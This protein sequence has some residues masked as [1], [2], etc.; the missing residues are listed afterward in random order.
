VTSPRPQASYATAR[1]FFQ[2]VEPIAVVTYKAPE[3]TEV[4]MALGFAMRMTC[5]HQDHQNCH[6]C[7]EAE[8]SP[9]S[10]EMTC[11]PGFLAGSFGGLGE[12]N[13]VL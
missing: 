9:M 12:E 11:A 10:C 13:D 3:P 1:R 7:L 4:V 6:R 8:L 5:H 2:L